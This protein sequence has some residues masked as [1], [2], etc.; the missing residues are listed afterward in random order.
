MLSCHLY[1]TG[2]RGCGKT[3][4]GKLLAQRL[5]IP[6]FDTDECIEAEAKQTI[7]EIFAAEGE[8]G[9]RH[10]ESATIEQLA[11]VP[12]AV[13]S[14]GGGAILRASNRAAIVQSGKA[15]WL[16]ASPE[17]L[18]Q[19]ILKDKHSGDNATAHRRPQLTK[20]GDYDEIVALLAQR[21]PLYREVASKCIQSQDRTPDEVCDEIVKWLES[22]EG[23]QSIH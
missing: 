23:S 20:L 9:F 2:Y 15:I 16:Q 11:S 19:R 21:E 5:S 17:I 12:P 8:A 18:A 6:F 10:R 7:A 22:F 4:A 14:L 1:L 3:T 13:I